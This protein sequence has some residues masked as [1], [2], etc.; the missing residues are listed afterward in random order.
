MINKVSILSISAALMLTSCGHS[1]KDSNKNDFAVKEGNEKKTTVEEEPF[2]LENWNDEDFSVDDSEFDLSTDLPEST[3]SSSEYYGYNGYGRGYMTPDK[4]MR[5]INL[6]R[7]MGMKFK[8]IG[9]NRSIPGYEKGRQKGELKMRYQ[10]EIHKILAEG[11][12]E[13]GSYY[14]GGMDYPVM[15]KEVYAIEAKLDELENKY[16][17]EKDK[18]EAAEDY[19]GKAEYKAKKNLLKSK[20]KQQKEALKR[21]RDSI[22]YSEINN[23]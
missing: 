8:A 23:K 10:Q 18:L 11:S 16:D 17:A 7:E 4:K 12:S 20:Y 6:K 21:K 13:A 2:D 14:G 5:I 19:M 1:L 22:I 3:T 9:M 15:S